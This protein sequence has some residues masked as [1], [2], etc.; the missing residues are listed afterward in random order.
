MR[1]SAPSTR[2]ARRARRWGLPGAAA[3]GAL[4]LAGCGADPAAGGDGEARAD[5]GEITLE[6]VHGLGVDPA[7][8]GL[9]AGTHYGVV[10]ISPDGELTRIADRVQDFMGFTVVGPQH[11]LASGH[12]GAGQD[13]PGDLGLIESTD[14]GQTWE[15]LS[16]AGEADFHALDAADGLVYGYSGGRLLVSE[17]GIEWADRGDMRIADLAA[18]PTDPQRVLATTEAGL[19][20]SED[21]GRNFT[22]VAGA[23]LLALVDITADGGTAAGVAPD[24]TVFV[25][26]DGGRT[27][28][29]R[30]STGGPPAAVTVEG[31]EVYV[32]VEGAVLAS[33]DG[34]E[35]FTELYQE[36]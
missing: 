8:D 4:V 11:Y 17:D 16:L 33:T 5:G 23:P 1:S 36:S 29:E 34:G 13:G 19:V 28:E 6:H 24:G 25:S 26:T 3:A 14:G 2:P 10:R 30:G 31:D 7:D 12:P 32:A 35:T 21:A 15:T 20:V 9:Y 27:W 22:A 18:D